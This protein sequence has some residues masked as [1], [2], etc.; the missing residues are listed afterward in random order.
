MKILKVISI[1]LIVVLIANL[2]LFGLGKINDL[3]FWV[4]I[5]ICGLGSFMIKKINKD[6][7]KK[8]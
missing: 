4:N 5:G 6:N 2:V 3:F 8:K 7:S 1:V